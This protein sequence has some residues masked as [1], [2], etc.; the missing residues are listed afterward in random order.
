MPAAHSSGARRRRAPRVIAAL[1]LAFAFAAVG[2]SGA[3]FADS[4]NPATT[5]VLTVSPAV[6]GPGA[7]VTM[8]ATVTGVG[9]SP[10]GTVT[11][12]NGSIPIVTGVALVPTSGTTSQAVY[13]TNTLAAA[14][15]SLVATYNSTSTS[16]FFS[17]IS[18]AVPLTVNA[19]TLY[20][21]TT[22]LSANPAAINVGQPGTLTAQ[23]AEIGGTGIPTGEVAFYDGGVFVA[24]V[25]VDATGTA[26][27]TRS[28]FPAGQQSFTAGYGGDSINLPSSSNSVTVQATGTSPAVQTTTTVT[29]TPNPIVT[30]QTMTIT[31]HVVQTG[32]P[33]SPP[34]GEFVNFRTVGVLGT[35]LAQGA[36]DA[37]GNATVTVGSWLPGSYVIEADYV[38]DIN[39]LPSSGT[40]SAG[41]AA[42]G[43]DL[44]VTASA[45]PA[46]VHTGGQITYSL[47][48]ANGGLQPAAN[49]RL[50]DSL[51][52]GTSFVSVTPGSPT[53]TVTSGLLGC[54]LG[55]MASGAQQTVT[56]VVTVGPG[57]AGTT[58][59][60]TAQVTSDTTDPNAA[61]NTATATTAVRASANVSVTQTAPASVPAGGGI[62]YTITVTNAGP[63][64]A[65]AVTLADALPAGL[66]APTATT[67]A[68]SCS[69]VSGALSC[70]LGT[71][72]SGAS[73]TVTVAGTVNT[74]ATSISNTVSTSSSTDD[75]NA[76]NNAATAVTSVTS[77]VLCPAVGSAYA[78]E[79]FL[80]TVGHKTQTVHVEVSGDCDRDW[81][82]GKIFLDHASVRVQIDC[83]SVLIDA[84]Q[85]SRHS[86]ITRVAITGPHDA[87]ITGTWKGTAFTVTLHDGGAPNKL[88]TVRVQYGSFDTS[89]LSAKHADVHIS[90]D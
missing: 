38:G 5:T 36:L 2:S 35:Y 75:P 69:I 44:S 48:V 64:A 85:D 59:A 86:D 87:V 84:T 32:A 57:L 22:T 25:P 28:D 83:Q 29:A 7:T 62:L 45:A 8:T 17:S 14:T 68:G 27:L 89:T 50:T 20:S 37:N 67:T 53:C 40:V 21:T 90:Q 47:V 63:E 58:L 56:L 12:S 76:A 72:A 1:G 34:A 73:V 52:A 15:Y 46:T 42:P 79:D 81:R 10:P 70:A 80:Q 55:T 13:A 19:T 49:V 43:A 24:E 88:D 11:F 4:T 18:A 6:A 71:F 16:S 78:D 61:N 66:T 9:G 74:T 33:T 26:T 54:S 3:A 77:S 30:G 41:V 60:D 39:D 65:A 23:V 31:A 82:T 51:P